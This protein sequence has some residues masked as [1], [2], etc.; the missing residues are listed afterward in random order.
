MGS[1]ATN[2][3]SITAGDDVATSQED[4]HDGNAPVDPVGAPGPSQHV[5]PS[6]TDLLL[7]SGSNKVLL[8]SQR[9]LMRA[10]FQD[11]FERIRAAMVSKNA[12]PNTFEAMEM[13]TE[14]LVKA[15]EFNDRAT[16]IHNRLLLDDDYSSSMSRLVS[17]WISNRTLLT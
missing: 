5:W 1:V 10:V 4:S 3:G 2:I 11:T 13:I 15:A 9:P 8:T 17:C 14:C 6:E 12:F 7:V 16:N